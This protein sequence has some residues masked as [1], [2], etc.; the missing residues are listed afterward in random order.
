M[1]RDITSRKALEAGLRQAQ[2]EAEAA[3]A[4]KADFLANMSH[5]LRTP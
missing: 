3:T 1:V 5:E 2:A 4:V